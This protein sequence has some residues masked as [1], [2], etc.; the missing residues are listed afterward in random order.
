MPGGIE[1]GVNQARSLAQQQLSLPEIADAITGFLRIL[2]RK[3]TVVVGIDELD[4][5][6]S[7][8][9]AQKFL[10]DIKVVFGGANVFFLVSV[11]ENAMSH[12]ERRG[13]PFRDAFD[14]AFDDIVVVNN[15]DFEFAQRLINER[16]LRMPRQFQALCHVL[17]SGLPRELVRTTRDLVL[18]IKRSKS[19]EERELGRITQSLVVDELEAKVLA[20]TAAAGRLPATPQRD[21]FLLLLDQAVSGPTTSERLFQLHLDLLLQFAKPG[22]AGSND[23]VTELSGFEALADEVATYLYFLSVVC[24]V[25]VNSLDAI[26]MQKFESGKLFDTLARVRSVQE[27]NQALARGMLDKFVQ[28]LEWSTPYVSRASEP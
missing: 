28:Q 3:Y 5:I 19:P 15:L 22:A 17:S 10:N 2:A 26:A 11:S 9:K 24:H 23:K 13:L 1:G 25:F 21:A 16:V 18:A 6:E 27:R 4:K 8:E 12:F 7:D 20:Y 14:S